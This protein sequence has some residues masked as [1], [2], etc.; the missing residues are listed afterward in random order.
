MCV[1]K[2][3]NC[4]N[5]IAD[6]Y[7]KQK[8]ISEADVTLH[9]KVSTEDGTLMKNIKKAAQHSLRCAERK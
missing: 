8:N 3:A 6:Y 1:L 7:F 4:V 2:A 9:C 5:D